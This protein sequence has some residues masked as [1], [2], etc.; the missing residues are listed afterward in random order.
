MKTVDFFKT[1]E[2]SD[3][4]V[5]KDKRT[6]SQKGNISQQVVIKYLDFF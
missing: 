3:L 2:A 5:G 4:K 1:I 6:S